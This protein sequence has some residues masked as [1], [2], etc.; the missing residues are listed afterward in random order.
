M[1]YYKSVITPIGTVYIVCRESQITQLVLPQKPL[2]QDLVPA[3]NNPLLCSAACQLEE[4]F[5]K[6]RT[7][8]ELP[9]APS[10]TAFRLSVWQQLLKIPYGTT[11]SYGDVAKLL[12]KPGAA[13]AV[14]QANRYNPLPIFIP[15]H[16]VINANGTLGGYDGSNITLKHFLLA[17]EKQ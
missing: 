12:G 10:G 4:Y 6:K 17:L 2:F 15:C 8:F 1:Q 7:V 11:L 16:R 3:E 9:L 13:Q 14:G 5:A